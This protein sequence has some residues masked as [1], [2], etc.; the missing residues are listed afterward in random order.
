MC[1]CACT[2]KKHKIRT[3]TCIQAKTNIYK[4]VEIKDIQWSDIYRVI[5]S[6]KR[7]NISTNW[8]SRPAVTFLDLPVA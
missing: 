4:A 3:F 7:S 5:N 6:E 2:Q 8:V 1:V